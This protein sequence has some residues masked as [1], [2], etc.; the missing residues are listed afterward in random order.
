MQLLADYI[1][2]N[3]LF[4]V[5]QVSTWNALAVYYYILNLRKDKRW[6]ELGS[7]L[8]AFSWAVCIVGFSTLQR[9]RNSGSA[10]VTASRLLGLKSKR[11]AE[12]GMSIYDTLFHFG[13]LLGMMVYA[14]KKSPMSILTFSLLL[15][16]VYFLYSNALLDAAYPDVNKKFLRIAA[17]LTAIL[18][19][20][21]KYKLPHL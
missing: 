5:G 8:Y 4:I 13:P 19:F 12:V 10:Y 21:L 2:D 9:E 14:P 20:V 11:S 7:A 15:L 18:A 6:N 17:P 16:P 1:N 3:S